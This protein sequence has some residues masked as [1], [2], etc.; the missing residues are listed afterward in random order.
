MKGI[1]KPRKR[2]TNRV[3]MSIIAMMI[4]TLAFI[5]IA[6]VHAQKEIAKNVTGFLNKSYYQNI[7]NH[8]REFE[9]NVFHELNYYTKNKNIYEVLQSENSEELQNILQEMIEESNYQNRIYYLDFIHVKKN[10]SDFEEY[11]GN[12]DIRDRL[13]NNDF[14]INNRNSKEIKCSFE[15]VNEDVYF[16]ALA[17]IHNEDNSNGS[18]LMA[19]KID[20]HYVSHFAGMMLEDFSVQFIKKDN[21]L[22]TKFNSVISEYY[23][24]NSKDETIAKLL[25]TSDKNFIFSNLK[26]MY[27][28]IGTVLLV[29][30]ITTFIIFFF[31]IK[32]IRSVSEKNKDRL[33]YIAKGNYHARM[34]LSGYEELDNNN[35]CINKLIDEVES[36]ISE[37]QNSRLAIIDMLTSSLE[38]KDPYTKG[39]SVRV[40]EYS[41][42]IAKEMGLND[43]FIEKLKQAAL[44]HDIGKIGI[45]EDILNKPAQLT[46]DEYAKVK[47]HPSTAAQ[48]LSSY[49]AFKDLKEIVISHHER[50]DGQ[51]YPFGLKGKDIPIGGRIISVADTFDAVTSDRVYRKGMP[52]DRAKEILLQECGRQFDEDIVKAFIKIV[53]NI[54]IKE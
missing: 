21:D 16:L 48:I 2:V 51:G 49:E 12:S 18:L 46:N 24:K 4:V 26:K 15:K 45:H 40:A 36:T 30:I 32:K 54:R 27:Y 14:Y 41:C 10:S 42:R 43:V 9:S 44:L 53:D 47:Q 29:S 11:F 1:K 28:L 20:V 3:V 25:V 37:L 7:N 19:T 34:E 6:L 38:A 23:F 5:I 13:L 50:F 52:K 39:H 22:H 17:Q 31:I 8:I 33:T 35:K